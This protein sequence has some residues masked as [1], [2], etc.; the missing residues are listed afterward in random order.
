VVSASIGISLSTT[1]YEHAEDVIRDADTAMYSAKW[2]A[3]GSHAI[4]NVA[5]H[6]KAVGRLR[7]EADLRRALD[8][9]ELE[10]H[11]QPV[12]ALDGS[13]LAGYEALV[14]WR[15]PGRGMIPPA[16][17]L[18]IAEDSG[19]M[20]PLGRW[21]LGESCRRLRQWQV[22]G[23]APDGLRI[24]VNV[25]SRQFWHGRLADDVRDSLRLAGIQPRDLVLEITEGVLMHDVTLARRTLA[26]LHEMGVRLHIDNF[27]TGYSSLEALCRLPL[28]A[29]EID[30]S[31]VARLGA[32]PRSA[33]LVRTI[34]LMGTNLGLTLHA[35]GIETAEQRD[36][37]RRAG[38]AY[39]QGLLFSPPLPTD[40]ATAYLTVGPPPGLPP[41]PPPGPRDAGGQVPAGQHG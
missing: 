5:M 35:E 20:L 16:E 10:V 4:F 39:G 27:G 23:V 14:R 12:V 9:G 37:L 18:A 15:Q 17:F 41:G 19:L 29:L 38:C 6:A 40:Q 36:H 24:G 2:R 30:R 32:D 33:E 7:T 22:S 26:E 34:V 1:G 21:V 25:S 11:Y 31:F 8:M 28:D 13:R 3:K